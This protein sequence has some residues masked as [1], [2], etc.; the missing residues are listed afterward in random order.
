MISA[1]RELPP[2]PTT[3]HAAAAYVN[4]V[5]PT[6]ANVTAPTNTTAAVSDGM[7]LAT[8]IPPTT[9]V[10]SLIPIGMQFNIFILFVDI[11]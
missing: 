2:L 7:Q 11:L 3:A 8:A 1:Y 6:S 9:H 4:N 10:A 5:L